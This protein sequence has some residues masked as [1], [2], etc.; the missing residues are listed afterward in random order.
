MSVLFKGCHICNISPNQLSTCIRHLIELSA[1][2]L[3]DLGRDTAI[4]LNERG[5]ARPQHC[6]AVDS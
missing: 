3:A 4:A 2:D 5:S 6:Q 1:W